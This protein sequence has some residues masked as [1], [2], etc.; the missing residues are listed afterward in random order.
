MKKLLLLVAAFLLPA[1][2]LSAQTYTVIP[3]ATSYNAAGGQITF[4]VNLTYPSTAAAVSF[5]AK[6]PTSGWIYVTTGGSQ[7]PQVSPRGPS[8]TPP[9]S[10]DTTDP[11]DPNSKWGWSYQDVPAGGSASFT[12]TIAYPAGLTGTQT[13]AFGGDYRLNN[14]ATPVTVSS[15]A[16]NSPPRI[17]Q[18]PS[19]Q[20]VAVGQPASF[21]ATAAGGPTPTLQWE[22]STNGGSTWE[23][24]PASAPYSGVTSGTLAISATTAAMN[25]YQ[26]RVVAANG[27]LPNAPSN[28]ATLN[29][30]SAPAFISHPETQSI[31]MGTTLTM[32]VVTSG[33][34]APTYQWKKGTTNLT[35]VGRVSGATSATLVITG[36]QADDAGAYSVVATNGISPD[37]TS[38][39]AT[40]TVVPAGFAATHAVVGAGYVAGSTVTV[41]N[42]LSYTGAISGLG[43]KISLPAGWSLVSSAGNVEVKPTGTIGTLSWAWI[44]PPTSPVTFTYTVNVP[45]GAT[46]NATIPAVGTVAL[47]GGEQ[48]LLLAKADPLIISPVL[49]HAADTNQDFAIDL[50]ELLRVIS[51]YNTRFTSPE[52]LVQTGCYRV[53]V[54]SIDGFATDT[55]KAAPAAPGEAGLTRYH[56]ADTNRDGALDLNELLRVISLYNTRFTSPEG[57]IQTGF[58]RVQVGTIDGYATDPTRAPTP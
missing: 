2:R 1:F 18:H 38:N 35:N 12:F 53:Q 14:V 48:V 21:T 34:P 7:T 39:T 33:N 54:G 44:T 20:T 41:T 24:V 15:V 55:T 49:H 47:V 5:F 3:S 50:N 4:T 8:T 30:T 26:F 25:G 9:Y 52:G 36:V 22:R 32:T 27:V 29:V 51:L 10:G 46:G 23:A 6:P 31:A 42:T 17:V 43:W 11:T 37:A 16:L 45:A 28:A 40:I 19:P 13:I 56:S 57:L 58:Y